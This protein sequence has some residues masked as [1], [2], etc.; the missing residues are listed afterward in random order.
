MCSRLIELS[1]QLLPEGQ[2]LEAAPI[3]WAVYFLGLPVWRTEARPTFPGQP[4]R[5][6]ALEGA[7]GN[8]YYAFGG[9]RVPRVVRAPVERLCTVD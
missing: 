8:H 4:G 6:A 5:F 9:G 2:L 1:Y 3:R 7:S